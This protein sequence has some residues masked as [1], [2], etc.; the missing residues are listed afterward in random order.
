MPPAMIRTERA[1]SRVVF[2]AMG[3][4]L[5]VA[6]IDLKTGETIPKINIGKQRCPTWR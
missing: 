3:R 1:N 4:S 2:A 6:I 5:P